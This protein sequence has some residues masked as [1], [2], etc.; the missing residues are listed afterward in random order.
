MNFK[1]KVWQQIVGM[2]KI[3]AVEKFWPWFVESI[4]PR[5]REYIVEVVIVAIVAFENKIKDYF[6]SSNVRQQEENMRKQEEVKKKAEEAAEMAK[7]ATSSEEAEKYTM[8]MKI[9]EEV[10]EDLKIQN[11]KMRS[12]L[13]E[14]KEILQTGVK[15][16]KADVEAQI[17]SEPPAHLH[18][19]AT[20]SEQIIL[21]GESKQ[22]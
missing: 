4:W 15:S 11:N 14:L 3:W 6:T 19:Q 22:E 12:E 20:I 5:I 17:P 10:L 8:V 13:E 16:A 7:Q 9:W 21:L 18:I 2:I 1:Q